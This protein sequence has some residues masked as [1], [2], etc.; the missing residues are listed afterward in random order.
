MFLRLSPCSSS[1]LP[2]RPHSLFTSF[3]RLDNLC[4]NEPGSKVKGLRT[5]MWRAAPAVQTHPPWPL[6]GPWG[7]D[8][9]GVAL[10]HQEPRRCCGEQRSREC[11]GTLAGWKW[12]VEKVNGCVTDSFRWLRKWQKIWTLMKN[13]NSNRKQATDDKKQAQTLW[14][15]PA[16]LHWHWW[17]SQLILLLLLLYSHICFLMQEECWSAVCWIQTEIH[18]MWFCPTCFFFL[19]R[20]TN[21]QGED[22]SG[23][24]RDRFHL[25]LLLE[26]IEWK[27]VPETRSIAW[28]CRR[29]PCPFSRASALMI[30]VPRTEDRLLEEKLTKISLMEMMLNSK[31][32]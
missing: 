9:D 14:W 30:S 22:F 12:T 20:K 6:R 11:N 8:K 5:R 13:Q 18:P 31:T 26:T 32:L 29:T 10:F 17:I 21:K 25:R 27:W 23:T 19:T 3:S 16:N 4:I 28:P 1:C 7:E 15:T 24:F 2:P